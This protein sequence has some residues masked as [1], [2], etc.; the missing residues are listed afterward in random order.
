MATA[1]PLS[2]FLLTGKRALITGAGGGIGR[3]L[4]SLFQAAG[5]KVM[6][7]DIKASAMDGLELADRLE[8]D[9]TNPDAI[10]EALAPLEDPRV[11]VEVRDVHDV[12]QSAKG[13]RDLLV[14]DIDNGARFETYAIEGERGQICLNGAAARLVS[15]GD[16]VILITYAEYERDELATYVPRVV[17]VDARNRVI[18]EVSARLDAELTLTE[19]A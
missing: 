1:D 18:D 16:K 7:A 6:G 2:G 4:V 11:V 5:A 8:F 14:L 10:A 13:S 15:P 3:V 9:L 17:H 19:P 12:I